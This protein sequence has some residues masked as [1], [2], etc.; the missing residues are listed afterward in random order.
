MW[1]SGTF[2]NML[3]WCQANGIQ[4]VVNLLRY[5][6]VPL[7]SSVPDYT[8][9]DFNVE[10]QERILEVLKEITSTVYAGGNVLVHCKHGLHRTG[11]VITLWIAL[12]LAT[13]DMAKQ[14][15]QSLLSTQSWR[16]RLQEA[17]DIWSTGRQLQ[18]A[19]IEENWRRDYALES[20]NEVI[21]R[22]E[23]MPRDMILNWIDELRR[24][25]QQAERR[26]Q[27]SGQ[28]EPSVQSR[29]SLP[30]LP[31]PKSRQPKPPQPQPQPK[32]PQPK[33]RPKPPQPKPEAKPPQPKPPQPKPTP[34]P[35]RQPTPKPSAKKRQEPPPSGPPPKRALLR[36]AAEAAASAVPEVPV[37]PAV[38]A[39]SASS[40]EP[41]VPGA[42]WQQGDWRCRVCGN[43]NWR[44]RG[45]CNG[46]L[47]QCKAVRDKGFKP[48]DWYCKC[49]NWN[50]SRRTTCNRS[51]CQTSREEG[52]QL[53]P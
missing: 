10:Y 47:G 17:F 25:A 37:V 8:H 2:G 16:E 30:S 12:M 18:Q 43:H 5:P 34:Q 53:P 49:G 45:Y 4:R 51:K 48:G 52:E 6:D 36:T 42:E 39:S 20:W 14:S 23:Q 19:S 26:L 3:E 7:R 50:L 46:R 44:H 31:R 24:Q 33:Q 21:F 1:A 35:K 38:S 15:A 28:S 9:M 40:A 41:W 11:A 32:P 27:R 29:M 22:W 13:G